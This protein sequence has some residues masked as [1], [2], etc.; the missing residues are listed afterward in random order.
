[1]LT[2]VPEATRPVEGPATVPLS[3]RQERRLNQV[4]PITAAP[5][6]RLVW[7]H[8]QGAGTE[9]VR[10]LAAEF[11]FDIARRGYSSLP[12]DERLGA[13]PGL[14]LWR[15]VLLSLSRF[16]QIESLYRA[17]AKYQPEWVPPPASSASDPQPTYRESG[18]RHSGPVPSSSPPH[19][20]SGSCVSDFI[21]DRPDRA[22]HGG[23]G[24]PEDRTLALS[25]PRQRNAF[26]IHAPAVRIHRLV[27]ELDPHG[28]EPG[29]ESDPAF[30]RS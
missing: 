10:S 13:E 22:K 11:P 20:S 8:W 1:V 23:A 15:D 19:G 3:P 9:S 27:A 4:A 6:L 26:S 21:T 17:N 29:S 14:R 28:S 24:W 5:H 25:G 16:W 2:H 12:G 30:V 7:P 18:S